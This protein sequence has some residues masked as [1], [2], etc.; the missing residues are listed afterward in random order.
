MV[1][2]NFFFLPDDAVCYLETFLVKDA[3]VGHASA[4]QVT[5]AGGQLLQT[6]VIER[7]VGG[8]AYDLGK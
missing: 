1:S 4:T 5:Q 8:L 7:G 2:S 6:C 3:V